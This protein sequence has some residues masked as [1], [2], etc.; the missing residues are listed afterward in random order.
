MC[1]NEDNHFMCRNT[2]LV[3]ES[4]HL[5]DGCRASTLCHGCS[6]Q[7]GMSEF[8]EPVTLRPTWRTRRKYGMPDEAILQTHSPFL[9]TSSTH[10]TLI[11]G[12]F[13]DSIGSNDRN[14]S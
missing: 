11:I 1:Q 7:E 2:L 9:S 8:T 10:D 4:E 12:P 3:D 6:G 14:V 5:L 13:G